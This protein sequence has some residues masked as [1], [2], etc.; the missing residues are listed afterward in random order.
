VQLQAPLPDGFAVSGLNGG[1]AQLAPDGSAVLL[2]GA[3]GLWLHSLESGTS[4]LIPETSGVS[5]PFW[6]P[7]SQNIAF[8]RGGRLWRTA[9]RGGPV[10]DIAAAADSRGGTWS[11]GDVI[12]FAPGLSTGLYQVPAAGG[13]PQI[14]VAPGSGTS[15]E[16]IRYPSFLPDGQH[17]LFQHS[18]EKET[19][20]YL[21]SLDGAP[22]R[23]L[24]PVSSNAVY[25]P[26]SSG[27]NQGRLLFIVNRT[28]MGQPF[29]LHTMELTG[30]M[31]PI[32]EGIADAGQASNGAF[33]VSAGGTLVY[34]GV[35]ALGLQM[36]I[37][38]RQ[39]RQITAIGA[40]VDSPEAAL[41]RDSSQVV[42]APTTSR[43]LFLQQVAGG[44]P[45]QIAEPRAIS[46][47]W[48]RDRRVAFSRTGVGGYE[49]F[50]KH[51]DGAAQEEALGVAAPNATVTDWSADGKWLVYGAS[52]NA[53][54]GDI[55]ILPLDGDRTPIAFLKTPAQEGFGRFSPDSKWLAY[56][57]GVS[58]NLEV[59]VQAISPAGTAA[60]IKVR[61]SAAGS[62]ASTPSWRQDGR[63]LIYAAFN[64]KV[65]GVPIT[66]GAEIALG[67]PQVL[68]DLPEGARLLDTASDAQRFLVGVPTG[69]S[70]R[71]NV[72]T[73]VMN[74]QARLRQ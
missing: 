17:F 37:V 7:D 63:E 23:L 31:S 52:D 74:W 66:L 38:D 73:V 65:T 42:Y 67:T 27:Q 15:A 49:I 50:V 26:P 30:E 4:T 36:L 72:L 14:V 69:A 2:T 9:A 54:A 1:W 61:V 58:G 10:L 18:S 41:S 16:Y 28:L 48:S 47:V 3:A 60:G 32:A 68:F 53:T 13:T 34:A 59:F 5:Y 12:L 71:A 64:R 20:F 51:L 57:G 46:P 40:P 25:A 45:T 21:G 33:S 70:A 55:W 35:S 24:R 43:I 62:G 19:G 22:A 6:S 56:K 11:R 44:P 8:F 39:G 29:D